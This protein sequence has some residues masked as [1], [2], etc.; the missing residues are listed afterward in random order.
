MRFGKRVSDNV[1]TSIH[2]NRIIEDRIT[3]QD[4]VSHG[5]YNKK[6]GT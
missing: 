4:D 2:A 3:Q 1:G 6:A 5:Q